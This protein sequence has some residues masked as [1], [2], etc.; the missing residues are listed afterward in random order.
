MGR[1]CFGHIDQNGWQSYPRLILA[2]LGST[3]YDISLKRVNYC[4]LMCDG[5]FIFIDS[6][7]SSRPAL[8]EYVYGYW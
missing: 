5:R 1:F 8:Q 4:A 7:I 2:E 6:V 3:S